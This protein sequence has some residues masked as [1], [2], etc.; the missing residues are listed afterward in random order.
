MSETLIRASST[1]WVLTWPARL[2]LRSPFPRG[3]GFVV[4]HFLPDPPAVFEARLPGSGRLL[5]RY[6]EHVGTQL[7]IRGRFEDEEVAFLCAEVRAAGGGTIVDVGAHVGYFTVS[8]AREVGTSGQVIAV[9]PLA[10]NLQLL[11][12]N[13]SLNELDNVRIF[14]LALG[15]REDHVP[16]QVA[17]DP[18]FSSLH[19]PYLGSTAKTLS[20]RMSRLDRIWSECGRP[21]VTLVKVDVEGA[22]LGVLEGSEDLLRSCSPLVMLEANDASHLDDVTS[23]LGTRGYARSQ[24]SGFHPYNYVFRRAGRDGAAS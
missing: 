8:L 24:P 20:I 21:F 17:S 22:E 13:V 19:R 5:I 16:L 7:L 15:E 6:R 3:K 23:W 14:R 4:R 12:A 10:S 1:R 11:E 18:A 9:E 2:Y